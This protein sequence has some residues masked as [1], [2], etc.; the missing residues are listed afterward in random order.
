MN[1]EIQSRT[2]IKASLV[3]IITA[4][5]VLVLFVLPAEYNIDPTGLGQKMGLT[6]F[7]QVTDTAQVSA[8]SEAGE[9]DVAV[10]TV[11]AGSGVEYKLAMAKMQRVK[12]QWET[13]QG[14]VYLDLHGE[15][16]GDTSGYFE[17][18][19]ITTT[20]SMQGSFI[21]PFTGSHGW[22]WRNDSDRDIS[23]QLMFEGE[24]QIQGLK[25]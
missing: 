13:D 15:P 4:T 23:I 3:S 18:Y 7:S 21:A 14:Q 20:H 10:I 11:P 16:E 25:P 5:I 8:P 12:Y 22:Y 24:Y 2:L 19:S 17:S 6:V 1:T 9:T